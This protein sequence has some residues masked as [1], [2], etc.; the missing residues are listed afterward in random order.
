[1]QP[2]S[3]PSTAARMPRTPTA[4]W[5]LR[6]SYA[7][8]NLD[9]WNA[10]F[11]ENRP[12]QLAAGIDVFKVVWKRRKS[13]RGKFAYKATIHARVIDRK[14]AEAFMQEPQ[15]SRL[16]RSP[17]VEIDMGSISNAWHPLRD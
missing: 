17:Q 12:D 8:A 1:M 16:A 4:R 7:L 14:R 11:L 13:A 5:W 6:V 15:W 3:T 9:G 10:S 2:S